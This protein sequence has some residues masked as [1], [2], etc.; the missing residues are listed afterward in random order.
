MG[1]SV[2]LYLQKLRLQEAKQ[3][4]RE[5]N[6]NILAIAQQIGYEHQASLTRIF[7]QFEGITP[8]DYR[9]FYE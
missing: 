3:L 5:T 9:K 7:K 1:V 6:Y 8:R 2:Q 4:L